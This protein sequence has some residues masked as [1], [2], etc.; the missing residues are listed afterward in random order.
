MQKKRNHLRVKEGLSLRKKTN[1]K[2]EKVEKNVERNHRKRKNL[3][4]HKQQ[5]KKDII[6]SLAKWKKSLKDL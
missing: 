4:I 6:K 1:L 2:K 5:L 3:V